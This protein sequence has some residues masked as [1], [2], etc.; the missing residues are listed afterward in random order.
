M[1]SLTQLAETLY[2]SVLCRPP[3]A[4]E[5][6]MVVS[7]LTQHPQNKADIVQELLWGLLSSSE[8]RFMF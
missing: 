8:F 6:Q 1:D 5:T 4:E 3:D 7:L 2:L